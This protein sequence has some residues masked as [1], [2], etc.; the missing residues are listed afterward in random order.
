MPPSTGSAPGA[1]SSSLLRERHRALF[2]A[3]GAYSLGMIVLGAGLALGSPAYRCG[4]PR[5]LTAHFS[6]PTLVADHRMLDD[7]EIRQTCELVVDDPRGWW[8]DGLEAPG[9]ARSRA[10]Q[11]SRNRSIDSSADGSTAY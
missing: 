2:A 3:V 1:S 5:C 11:P 7:L 9:E 8:P 4:G 6:V 10:A